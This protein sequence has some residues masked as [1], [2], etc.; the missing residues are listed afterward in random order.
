MHPHGRVIGAPLIASHVGA[1][2][3]RRPRRHRARRARR[4]QRCSWTSARTPRSSSP[5]ASASWRRP[6]PPAR[7]SRAACCA[8]GCPARTGR[9]SRVPHRRT[10]ASTTE[11]IGD[12]SRRASAARGWST[13]WPSFG[14]SGWMS[15]EGRFAGR[16]RR[17]HRRAGAAHHVLA[18]RRQPARPGEGRQR[19]RPAHPPAPARRRRP[20]QVD[21]VFLAGGFANAIDVENAIAIGFLAPVPVDAGRARRQRRAARGGRCCCSHAPAATARRARRAASSTSSSRPEPDF[22]ELFVDGCQFSPIRA[23]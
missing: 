12:A 15:P 4:H 20:S 6:A 11:T 23:S 10:A 22:F 14:A 16:A 3:R 1:R 5:T 8:T 17:L 7:P 21:R 18:L 2:R 13:S 19:L 9:S